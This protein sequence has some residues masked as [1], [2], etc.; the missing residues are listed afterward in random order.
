MVRRVYYEWFSAFRF[1]EHESV[2]LVESALGSIPEGWVVR[3]TEGLIADG[4]LEIGD[5]YR[6]KNAEFGKE[7]LPFVRIRNLTEDLDFKDVDVLPFDALPRLHGKVSEPGDSVIS[8]KGTVGR[9]I[10]VTDLTPRFVYSPQ[11]SYWRL[12]DD[13]IALPY[14]PRKKYPNGQFQPADLRG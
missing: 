11:L 7:G 9:V 5:G 12:R 3:S 8:T 14:L 6:A 1:P 10:H 13:T 4:S 2:S